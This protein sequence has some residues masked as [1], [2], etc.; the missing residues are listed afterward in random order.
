MSNKKSFN[1]IFKKIF[2][3]PPPKPVPTR[4]PTPQPRTNPNPIQRPIKPVEKEE[5]KV[6][7]PKVKV[8]QKETVNYRAE[9][10]KTFKRLTYRHRSWDIWSDFIIMFAC[11]ISNAV[12]KKYYDE[13]EKLYLKT[14]KKYNKEEQMMFPE[15]LAHTVMALEMNQ[16][17]DFLG[18]IFM[19]LKLGNESGGQFFT[20]YHVCQFMAGI[21]LYTAL[22]EVEKKGVITLHDSCCGAGATLIAGINEVKKE[23]HNSKFN[24]QNHLL[25]TGQDIDF[26]VALMCY[27]QI[28]LLGVAGYIKVGN[29]LSDP[30]CEGDD[31][32]NYWY[33]PMYFSEVW[34][35]R[36][37]FKDLI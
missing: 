28:S 30:M 1:D 7:T 23:L 35:M 27:I 26:V 14:I 10:M 8:E 6:E 34:T 3:S 5:K 22:V 11:S 4:K 33:T 2:G 20:P 31:T 16:E 12:D 37:L 36:R 24:F 9:F 17:Q 15:L 18:S 13:R 19:D 21:T 32:N 29:S 25:V